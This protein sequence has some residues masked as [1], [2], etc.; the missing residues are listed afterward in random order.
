MSIL[1]FKKFWTKN[2]SDKKI[3]ENI[4]VI[5]MSEI[6]LNKKKIVYFA[7]NYYDK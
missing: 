3:F 4:N 7:F 2:L 1:K 6:D 5:L